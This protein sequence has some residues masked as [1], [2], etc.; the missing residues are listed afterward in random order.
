MNNIEL[1]YDKV[2]ITKV[3]FNRNVIYIN[4]INKA[5]GDISD[6]NSI[7]LFELAKQF[8]YLRLCPIYKKEIV[9]DLGKVRFTDKIT[10]LILDAMLYDL[11][12]NTLYDIRLKY[13]IDSKYITN[14]GVASTAFIRSVDKF[15]L[16]NKKEFLKNY[17]KKFFSDKNIYRRL[18]PV[19]DCKDSKMPSVVFSDVTNLVASL[20][21]DEEFLDGIGEVVSELF[22]N[23][24][25]HTQSDCLIDI[26][27]SSGE[28]NEGKEKFSVSIGIINF[29]EVRLFDKIKNNIKEN[30]YDIEDKL[31]KRIYK[32][33]ETHKRLFDDNYNEDDFFFITA[34]QNHVTSRK[35]KSGS[36]G[37]GLTKLIEKIIGKSDQDYSYVLSGN[38]ILIYKPEFL[39]LSP[40][41][42]IGFNKENDYFNNRPD[43]TV[44]ERSKLYIPGCIYQLLLI[45]EC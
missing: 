42:F 21:D 41:K 33:Y 36:F 27:I 37:T 16:I 5:S 4:T 40:D 25:S 2:P 45:K 32:A 7:T 3:K 22:C 38:N 8:K 23:V 14:N 19:E 35:Y 12:K 34:F 1:I 20:T 15:G 11:L 13:N 31:Y 26:N 9:I 10:Y 28:D 43:E 18:I 30:K 29:S 44:I 24:A 6:F 39:K 17:S